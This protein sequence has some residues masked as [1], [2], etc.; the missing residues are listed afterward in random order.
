MACGAFT[1]RTNRPEGAEIES[2]LAGAAMLW[3]DIIAFVE[4]SFSVS[5]DW[6][7]YGKNYGWS[8]AFKRS[9]KALVSLYPDVGSFTAQVILKDA[10]IASVPETLMI[11][12]LRAAIERANPYAEG[13]WIFLA[14][15]S[16][17]ELGVV[18]KLIEIRAAR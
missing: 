12:E 13:R 8:L 6:K 2:A 16:E 9:G 15:T 3:E 14:V 11:P 7:F 18:K 5:S 4:G 17:R 10:Q 1:D